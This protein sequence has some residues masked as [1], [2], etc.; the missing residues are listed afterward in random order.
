[1]ISEERLK[2]IIVMVA[3]DHDLA[4][5]EMDNISQLSK[6]LHDRGFKEGWRFALL[7]LLDKLEEELK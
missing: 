5:R 3:N 1:M 7:N 2:Q 4:Y 6:S